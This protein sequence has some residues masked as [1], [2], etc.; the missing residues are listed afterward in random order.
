[1]EGFE[2]DFVIMHN[3][4]KIDLE[5]DGDQHFNA[6]LQR[7]RQDL[8]RDRVLTRAGWEV[9]RFPA[10]RCFV[11]PELVTSDIAKHFEATQ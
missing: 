3:G 5:V 2:L 6:Q 1:V 7:C 10:W 4:R 8:L 9:L 11:E